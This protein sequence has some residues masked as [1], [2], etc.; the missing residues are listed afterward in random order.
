AHQ[1]AGILRGRQL[2]DL[3]REVIRI[4]TGGFGEVHRKLRHGRLQHVR[5]RGTRHAPHVSHGR[6]PRTEH[7]S[8]NAATLLHG[9]AADG[10]A[11]V[12]RRTPCRIIHSRLNSLRHSGIP[13]QAGHGRRLVF[14]SASCVFSRASSCEPASCTSVTVGICHRGFAACC[15][16]AYAP[17][18]R[19]A[20]KPNTTASLIL[21]LFICFS[22]FA[23]F[24]A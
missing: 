9:R 12:R 20:A 10:R 17:P 24:V 11:H 22:P 8:Q 2:H 3:R 16:C 18:P 19:P 23:T 15:A 4:D 7:S 13:G 6:L 14:V 21:A 5:R 1:T